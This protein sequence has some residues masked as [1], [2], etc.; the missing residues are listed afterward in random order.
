MKLK[1]FPIMISRQFLKGHPRAG[2][3]TQF[4]SKI[5]CK[6]KIHTI[7]DNYEYW[8]RIAKEVNAGRGVLSLRQWTGSPYNFQCDG[9]KPKEF[10]QL[11]KMG[12][13]KVSIWRFHDGAALKIT[14]PETRKYGSIP[15]APNVMVP[16][17]DIAFAR[18]IC[19]N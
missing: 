16:E 1:T 18:T 6:S 4:K 14:I 17:R 13:Q 19:T 2:E 5:F 15:I 10:L 8:A 3:E 11:P 12:V 7:R 9:S